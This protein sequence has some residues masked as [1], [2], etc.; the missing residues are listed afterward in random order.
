MEGKGWKEKDGR[1]AMGG[2]GWKGRNERKGGINNNHGVMVVPGVG[3]VLHASTRMLGEENTLATTA[4]ATSALFEVPS[5][6]NEGQGVEKGVGEGEEL[7]MQYYYGEDD[8]D[9]DS[10]NGLG[11]HPQI[12]TRNA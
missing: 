8:N 3:N 7:T 2:E 1:E 4:M 9:T 5:D 12:M 6:T 10:G 11:W